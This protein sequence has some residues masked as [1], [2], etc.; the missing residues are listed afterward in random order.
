MRSHLTEKPEFFDPLAAGVY[1]RREQLGSAYPM[2]RLGTLTYTRVEASVN[3][4]K[5]CIG[6]TCYQR[7]LG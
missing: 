1:Q 3:T 2:G 6:V 7:N 4:T 5:C